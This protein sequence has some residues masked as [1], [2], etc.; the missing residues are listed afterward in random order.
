MDRRHV[1]A[2][3][4]VVGGGPAGAATAIAAAGQGLSVILCEREPAGRDR[5]GETLHPGVEPVL[6]Q[7]GVADRLGEAIGAQHEGIWIEWGA[8]RRFEPFGADAD[9]PWQGLQVWRADFDGL[10]LDRAR[11]LGVAVHQPCAVNGF[12]QDGDLP[13]VETAHGPMAAR[14]VV[15]ASGRSRWLGRATGIDSPARSPQL[16]ARYGYR[17]GA[18]PARDAAPLLFGDAE[19]W[20]WS[21]RVRPGLYQ[22]TS[23]RFGERASDAVP[24]ELRD[25]A[26]W[27]AERGAD[28]TWRL[29]ERTAG[30]NWFMTGDAAA[31]LD[32]T[33]SR[34]V[35]KAL[36]SGITAA[37]L[38]A[39]AIAGTAPPEEIAAAYHGWISR[40][41][42]ADIGHLAAFY[43]AIGAPGFTPG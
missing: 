27:G 19:G 34:G 40:R 28:V 24:D 1:D 39:A 21:A 17:Q 43:G 41:F 6:R 5:P 35:L 9:G 15:D 36:L 29:A 11:Q 10:L 14:I 23:V 22:W 7:L 37:H 25:L 20:T 38:A 3:L 13:V 30:R 18:C 2:D 16:I 33:S 31:V 12:V 4:I 8:P 26:A 42:E 32:P